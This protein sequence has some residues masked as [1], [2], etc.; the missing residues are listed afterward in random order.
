MFV[1]DSDSVSSSDISVEI[2]DTET[3]RKTLLQ[4]LLRLRDLAQQGL[5]VS[6]RTDIMC[7]YG[8]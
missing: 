3:C 4:E 8:T 7:R 2:A 5:Q 6:W 1:T